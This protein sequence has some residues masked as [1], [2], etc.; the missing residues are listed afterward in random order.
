ME[1]TY[2]RVLAMRMLGVK[3]WM[4]VPEHV[5]MALDRSSQL[6]ANADGAI[7]SRQMVAAV[8]AMSELNA[9]IADCISMKEIQISVRPDQHVTKGLD[10]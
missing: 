1:T 6:V 7:A 3:H 9:G 10:Q 2:Y 8:I 5:R 4:D